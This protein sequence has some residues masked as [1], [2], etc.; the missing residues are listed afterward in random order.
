[1]HNNDRLT[2]VWGDVSVDDIPAVLDSFVKLVW[3]FGL[4]IHGGSLDAGVVVT[5][6]WRKVITTDVGEVNG[7]LMV[8]SAPVTGFTD[9]L[10]CSAVVS[11][12]VL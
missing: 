10:L 2:T 9:N 1:M 6:L 4:D 12:G 3:G 7:L 11:T 8:V 5:L